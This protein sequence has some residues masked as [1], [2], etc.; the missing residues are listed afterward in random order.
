MCAGGSGTAIRDVT[1][2][3]RSMWISSPD[4]SSRHPGL[5]SIGCEAITVAGRID[6]CPENTRVIPDAARISPP[7]SP[8]IERSRIHSSFVS[9]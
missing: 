5:E 2:R 9:G 8:P 6:S 3:S 1:F 7:S 4:S